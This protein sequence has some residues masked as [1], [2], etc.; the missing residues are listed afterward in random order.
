MGAERVAG[1]EGLYFL[2]VGVHGVRP[3]KIRK[4]HEFQ[5]LVSEG[6]RGA[7]VNGNTVEVSVYN[8]FEELDRSSC[9]DDRDMRVQLQQFFDRSGVIGLRVIHD[10]IVDL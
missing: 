2:D 5:G 7:V 10:Q 6:E 1:E 3:V 4:D 8:V 9:G